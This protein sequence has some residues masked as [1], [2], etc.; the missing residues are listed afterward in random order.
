MDAGLW[1]RFITPFSRRVN[2]GAPRQRY[3]TPPSA[4]ADDCNLQLDVGLLY[5]SFAGR[6]TIGKG[7]ILQQVVYY[8]HLLRSGY[9][10]YASKH[11]G[12]FLIAA[13]DGK[14][15]QVNLGFHEFLEDSEFSLDNALEG[16]DLVLKDCSG[17]TIRSSIS[18]V[19]DRNVSRIPA[20]LL[21][22]VI[23]SVHLD[24]H[25]HGPNPFH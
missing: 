8:G 19:D 13:Y 11:L 9:S 1:S 23:Y 24:K 16:F 14:E 21:E 6:K 2:K 5:E 7:G 17:K 20:T 15:L 3:V 4:V 12:W 25:H 10:L 18:P 22:P